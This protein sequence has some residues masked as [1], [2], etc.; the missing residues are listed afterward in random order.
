MIIVLRGDISPGDAQDLPIF[1]A[2]I[3]YSQPDLAVFAPEQVLA[4]L[5]RAGVR[6][7]LVSST[8]DDGTLKLYAKA[9]ERI[10]SSLRPYRS[11][12]DMLT[13]HS[14]P[15]V[16]TCVEER[17]SHGVYNS[18]LATRL[19]TE[20]HGSTAPEPLEE[21]AATLPQV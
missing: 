16:Q 14:D 12:E 17:L 4:I 7:A 19:L 8:P 21:I 15:A 2:H 11:R 18:T 3:H 6:H 5:D 1:D 9:P 10:V 13:W 20:I